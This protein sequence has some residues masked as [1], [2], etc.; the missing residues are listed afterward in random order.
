[1]SWVRHGR[2]HGGIYK[3]PHSNDANFCPTCSLSHQ[4][5]NYSPQNHIKS[6]TKDI[7]RSL[8]HYL[9]FLDK[10]GMASKLPQAVWDFSSLCTSDGGLR[11]PRWRKMQDVVWE[12]YYN[13][14]RSEESTAQ[15]GTLTLGDPWWIPRREDEEKALE[16]LGCYPQQ[17]Q[18]KNFP[19]SVLKSHPS[20][21]RPGA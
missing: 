10:Q 15:T 20:R 5:P 19:S 12:P 8:G 4:I 21:L 6:R 7:E 13:E 16:D 14:L 2:C 18:K 9:V 3:W 1:M 11:D 17:L